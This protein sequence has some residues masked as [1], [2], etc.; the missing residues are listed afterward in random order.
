MY[1]S[2]EEN[3]FELGTLVGACR[4]RL[5][6]Y[7]RLVT[8]TRAAVKRQSELWDVNAPT[9][10]DRLYRLLYGSRAALEEVML[11]GA[12]PNAATGWTTLGTC[13]RSQGS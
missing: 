13:R 1:D 2:I 8:A 3:L 10:T 11:E 5:P 4:D 7:I 12:V 9:T 6:A